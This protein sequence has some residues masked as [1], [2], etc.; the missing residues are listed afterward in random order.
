MPTVILDEEWLTE[1]CSHYHA[2]AI[3]QVPASYNAVC[4]GPKDLWARCTHSIDRATVA[5][6]RLLSPV[7]VHACNDMGN[8]KKNR[9]CI[10]LEE[11]LRATGA[12]RF[13]I[14]VVRRVLQR[15]EGTRTSA[16][17]GI[18]FLR[19]HTTTLTQGAQ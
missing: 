10:V 2:A 17:S 12:G 1:V 5:T 19:L 14:Q 6:D 13:K 11:E 15:L 4:V 7:R 16:C 9:A 18:H 3:L 8:E